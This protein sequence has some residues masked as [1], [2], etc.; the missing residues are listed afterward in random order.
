MTI[1]T[2]LKS[3]DDL[4]GGGL[5]PGSLT[6]YAGLSQS[7]MTTLLGTTVVH[8]ALNGGTPTMLADL[9]SNDRNSRILSA[10]SGVRLVGL[11]RGNLTPAEVGIV[12]RSVSETRDA[13]LHHTQA[14][15]MP[16][17]LADAMESGAKLIAI[18]GV[19]YVEPSPG[20]DGSLDAIL[21]GLR[22]L[23]HSRG[24]AIVI[25]APISRRDDR[26]GE[27]PR[28]SSLPLEFE[29][30]CD[31]VVL[32]HRWGSFNGHEST[33]DPVEL[34]VPKNRNGNCGQV[35]AIGDYAHACFRDRDVRSGTPAA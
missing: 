10:H 31:T 20:G 22:A 1:T 4:I 34:T 12:E 24:A 27:S 3:L 19:R 9:E 6:L 29:L 33:Q 17:L 25:T 16:H 32:L 5:Q 35:W 18:D 30:H 23:A 21:G 28:L 26:P 14:R 7:G 13:P 8:A 15:N 11:Q 2:G